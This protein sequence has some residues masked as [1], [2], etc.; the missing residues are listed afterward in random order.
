MTDSSVSYQFC[1]RIGSRQDRLRPNNGAVEIGKFTVPS[2]GIKINICTIGIVPNIGIGDGLQN[3]FNAGSIPTDVS[4]NQ[5][6]QWVYG[7]MA[8][9][10]A[11][12]ASTIVCG[13]ESLY[14]HQSYFL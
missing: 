10:L 12:G 13:F 11:L 3:H 7:G 2:C 14:T 6:F 5:F 9:A 8:D 4:N 1:I